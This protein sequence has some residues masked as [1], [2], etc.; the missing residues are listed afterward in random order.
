MLPA[1]T[2]SRPLQV[3]VACALRWPSE[4]CVDPFWLVAL[5]VNYY[6]DEFVS[7]QSS[8]PASSSVGGF[9]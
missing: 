2:A 6:S 3:S 9:V 4:I 1:L 7:D 8:L 5:C